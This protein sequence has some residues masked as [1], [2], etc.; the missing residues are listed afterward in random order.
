[1]YKQ[2]TSEADF[3]EAVS[4]NETVWVLKHSSVCPTSSAALHEFEAYLNDHADQSACIVIVQTERPVSNYIATELGYTHQSPQLFLV[5]NKAVAWQ[6]S[7]WSITSS[8]MA[9]AYAVLS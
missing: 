9:Q 8:A 4:S 2:L 7:H 1:M 3:D 6:A 5:H